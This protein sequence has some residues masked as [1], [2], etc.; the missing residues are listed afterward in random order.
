[1]SAPEIVPSHD[2]PIAEQAALANRA[3]GDYLIPVAQ[4]AVDQFA[5]LMSA[6]GVDLWLSRHLRT[7][8]GPAGFA[9]LNRTGGIA[10]LASMGFAPEARHQ[11]NGS[12]LLGHVLEESR[13]RGEPLMTLEVFEQNL[14]AV[15]L[16]RR[17]GFRE[18]GRLHGWQRSGPGIFR[19]R[20]PQPPQ[21]V[22]LQV[23]ARWPGPIDYPD[24]PWQVSRTAVA[25]LGPGTR[26]YAHGPACVVIGDPT[27]DTVRVCAL[28]V[29]HEDPE[30]V[31]LLRSLL[32]E[33]M[34]LHPDRAW[35]APQF[36]P[37]K[38]GREI[39]EPLGFLREPLNQF[40]M[41]REL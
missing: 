18:T 28:F 1:M 16:Y 31:D 25:R 15:A 2:L 35:F 30:G 10:R 13:A 27:A 33:V 21:P 14:P 29:A 3:F 19:G 24:I 20:L 36:H 5:R 11:G 9:Y 23:A 17:H 34:H 32:A 8:S 4:Y 26:A 6:Q 40:L 38:V 37:E 22:P 39:F 41:R 12:R 7:A